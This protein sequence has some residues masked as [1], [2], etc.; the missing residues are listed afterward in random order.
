MDLLMTSSMESVD[1]AAVSE[2]AEKKPHGPAVT[3]LPG[4]APPNNN[5]DVADRGVRKS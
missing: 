2:P 3:L 1:D 5:N 4:P